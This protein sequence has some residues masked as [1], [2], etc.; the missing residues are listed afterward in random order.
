MKFL[1]LCHLLLGY[2]SVGCYKDTGLDRAISTLEGKDPLLDGAYWLRANPTAKCAVAAIRRGYDMFAVQN[3]GWCAASKTAP[4][5]FNKHG[6]SKACW[7]GGE[8]GPWANEVY[9]IVP[10]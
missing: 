1:L 8:G 5:R 2:V 9:F 10:K 4:K 7:D 6:P 3:S